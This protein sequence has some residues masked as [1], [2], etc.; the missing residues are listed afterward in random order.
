M[1]VTRPKGIARAATTCAVVLGVVL[2]AVPAFAQLRTR[3]DANGIEWITNPSTGK[4]AAIQL[5]P[6]AAASLT[7]EPNR[8]ST[9]RSAGSS[10]E[11]A[12]DDLIR[13]HA[14]HYDVNPG[15]V[16][17]V[18]QVESNFNPNA[19]SAKGA[20]GLM[21]LMPATARQLGVENP[22]DPSENIRGG[23]AYLRQLLDRYDGSTRL[24]LAAYNAGP[25]AVDKYGETVPPY[26]ETR[27]YVARVNSVADAASV[28][29]GHDGEDAP[30]PAQTAGGIYKIVEIKDGRE[31]ITFTNKKPQQR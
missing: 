12:Y 4:A 5:L 19:V 7:T 15:L 9:S 29:G 18:V 24:A 22:F 26:R 20:L 8:L 25:G 10:R 21:Q 23:T 17:A 1:E 14:A 30:L 13:E 11:S 2:S 6:A 28:L 27:D 3:V 16:R 31:V